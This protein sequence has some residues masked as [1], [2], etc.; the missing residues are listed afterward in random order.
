MPK[1]LRVL[2]LEGREADAEQLTRL[3]EQSGFA[4]QRQRVDSEAAYLAALGPEI[5]L[6][7]AEA[8][9]GYDA[10]AALR[11]LRQRGLDTPFF[12]VSGTVD[13]DLAVA[14]MKEGA[15]DFLFKDR[16]A[17]L[18]RAVAAALEQ[19]RLRG[20]KRLAEEMLRHSE[21]RFRAIV[22]NSA[23]GLALLDRTG[24][25]TYVTPATSQLLGYRPEELAGRRGIDVI[26]PADLERLTAQVG[27]GLAQPGGRATGVCRCRHRDGEWRWIEVVVSNLLAEPSVQA[28][29]V[30]YRDITLRMQLERQTQELLLAREIQRGLFPEGIPELAGLDVA[31]RSYPAE[32]VGGDYFDFLPLDD[33][34][35]AVVIGDVSGHGFGPALVMAQTHAALRALTSTYRVG[36]RRRFDRVAPTVGLLEQLLRLDLTRDGY[37][38]LG[39]AH[40]DLRTRALSYVGAGHPPGFILDAAGNVKAQLK[41][42]NPPLGVGQSEFHASQAVPLDPGDLVLLFTDGIL[43]A[44]APD[45]TV[46]GVERGLA[47][48]RIYRND[49]ASEIVRNLYHAVRAFTLEGPQA[50]DMTAIVIKV[51]TAV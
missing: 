50:D 51:N 21:M 29:V 6:V 23:D 33:R 27:D 38:T 36:G 26:H 48:V 4:V 13:E 18:G 39:L 15:D 34:G 41:C 25:I 47:I 31:G 16:L 8:L 28:L 46:F 35:L 32:I 2:M 3:L 42:Q 24:T 5:D 43:E 10:L 19:R 14:C 22:E 49:P 12:I 20:E 45:G 1:P 44:R 11:N 37:L 9:P 30:N 40:L 7:L 17:R